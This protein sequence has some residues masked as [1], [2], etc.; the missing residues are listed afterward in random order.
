MNDLDSTEAN[1]RWHLA[2]FRVA[3]VVQ[4]DEQIDLPERRERSHDIAQTDAE[5]RDRGPGKVLGDTQ[6]PHAIGSYE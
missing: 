5:P 2:R 6:D 1:A 3:S 4:S